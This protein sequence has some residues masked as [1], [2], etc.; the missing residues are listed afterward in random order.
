MASTTKLYVT[1]GNLEAI[2]ADT[3][4]LGLDIEEGMLLWTPA[5]ARAYFSSGGTEQPD[6]SALASRS[7]DDRYRRNC[8]RCPYEHEAEVVFMF[9]PDCGVCMMLKDCCVRVCCRKSKSQISDS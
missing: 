2:R 7:T 5:E 1:R 4:A 3:H 8:C 6:P 9:I